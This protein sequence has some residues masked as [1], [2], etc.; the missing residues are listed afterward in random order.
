[1]LLSSSASTVRRERVDALNAI[2]F[3]WKPRREQQ[4]ENHLRELK[5]YK[6]EE[7]RWLLVCKTGGRRLHAF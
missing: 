2:H 7:R 1:M 4:W 5:E 6:G 3:E